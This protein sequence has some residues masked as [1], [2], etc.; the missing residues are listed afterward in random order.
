MSAI[1]GQRIEMSV[2]SFSFQSVDRDA[3]SGSKSC[4]I[5]KVMKERN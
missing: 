5:E 2:H 3:N 1:A 4:R